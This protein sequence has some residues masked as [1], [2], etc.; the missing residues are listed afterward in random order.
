MV[1]SLI[2]GGTRGIGLVVSEHLVNR[3]DNVYTA[4]RRTLEENNHI[5]CDITKDCSCLKLRV[6][7]LDNLIFTHRYRGD[8]WEKTF[9]V[10]I[11]G[12]EN[13]IQTLLP[14]FSKSGGSVVIIS[15]NASSF[16][17]QEQSAEYN[18][19]RS[20]LQ[21]LARYYAVNY[22][23]KKLR[24]NT[25]L[26]STLIKPENKEFFSRDNDVRSII[27]KITPL[28]RMGSSSDVAN[29]V[30]FLCSDQSCFITGNSFFVDGGLSLVGQETIARDI[31]NI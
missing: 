8:D 7:K 21:G 23:K 26:P 6:K 9:A 16:V 17:L 1:T 20:A 4:S 29:L 11:K 3:G 25:I 22:G 5:S 12:V 27:E 18:S 31:A 19:S 15:S 28:G 2:I 13:V 30:E 10:T 14:N 24:F